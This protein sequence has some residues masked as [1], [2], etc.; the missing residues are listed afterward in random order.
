VV[1]IVMGVDAFGVL[2]ERQ[3]RL[4]LGQEQVGRVAASEEAL[5]AVFPVNYLV[6]SDEIPFFTGGA[7]KLRAATATARA[8]FEV[9]RLDPVAETGWTVLVVGLARE[10]T[11][12]VVVA[13]ARAPGLR[14]FA[15]GD[16]SLSVALT[17]EVVSGRGAGLGRGS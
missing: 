1:V 11:E 4:L 8:T 7:T 17:T 15:D 10:V 3:C 13:G 5:T 12:P 14:P 9:D 6:V 2:S 16:R